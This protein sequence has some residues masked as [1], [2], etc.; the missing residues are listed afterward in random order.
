MK[1]I[2]YD[3][4]F[5]LTIFRLAESWMRTEAEEKRNFM[6]M[7]LISSVV[8]NLCVSS[9]STITNK[10]IDQ[11]HMQQSH[12]NEISISSVTALKGN[13]TS[14][15][16]VFRVKYGQQLIL[17]NVNRDCCASLPLFRCRILGPKLDLGLNY[18][19]N[20]VHHFTWK[21]KSSEW[22]VEGIKEAFKFQNSLIEHRVGCVERHSFKKTIC[23]IKHCT[24]Y[25][26]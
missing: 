5:L 11:M 22:H 13:L 12:P 4:L 10:C 7:V 23:H 3:I 6:L 24:K 18:W 16:F 26:T 9:E 19:I 2:Y 1:C 14:K 15:W 25:C 8:N 20:G 17:A 21:A